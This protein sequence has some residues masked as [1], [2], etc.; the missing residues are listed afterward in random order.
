[1]SANYEHI[2]KQRGAIEAFFNNLPGYK[3]K[4]TRWEADRL[5]REALVRDFTI[6]LDRITAVQNAVLEKLGVEWM[7]ALGALKTALQTLIDRIRYA[8]R[9][10]PASS[11]QCASRKNS[12]TSSRRSTSNW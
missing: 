2:R 1:M 7:G 6:Q 9:A 11:T 12:S 8:P 3:E 10:T 4:E 5:L